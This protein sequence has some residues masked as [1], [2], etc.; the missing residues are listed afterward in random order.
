MTGGKALYQSLFGPIVLQLVLILLNAFFSCAEIAILTLNDLSLKKDADSGNKKARCL[1]RLTS[2]PSRFLATIQVGIT[3]AGFLASAFAAQNFSDRLVA[4]LINIGVTIPAETLGTLSVIAITLL[5]SYFTLVLGELVPKRIAMQKAKPI[6]YSVSRI[7]LLLSRITAPLVW[8]L[9]ASTNGILRL[10]RLSTHPKEANV[11]EEEIRMLVDLG[12]ERGAI[13]PDEGRMIDNVL[14]LGNKCAAE[15]M[16][17]RTDLV[18]LWMEESPEAWRDTIISA[19][20]SRYLVCSDS[21]D[22][23]AG[24]LHVR[25]F[26]SNMFLKEPQKRESI[27][28]PAFI[29]PETVRADVLFREMKHR[30]THMAVVI[31]EYGGLGGVITME[32]LLEEIVGQIEDE[33][34]FGEPMI[35]KLNEN[36][37]RAKGS[38][39]IGELS[40]YFGVALPEGDYDTLGGLIF[41]RLNSI[42]EDG[43]GIEADIAGLH[44]KVESLKYRRVEWAL[45]SKLPEKPKAKTI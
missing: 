14:E 37:W 26:F 5:L 19:N 24:I 20:Y 36:L 34:D 6:A 27:I 32:D 23:I 39:E 16:T 25:D 15:L 17:P 11:T 3:I 41:S 12:E 7:I 30:K 9:T 22:E 21:I 8:L 35:T 28:R 45:I 1:V 2:Q 40:D 33:H 4:W 29:V 42:P 18:V 38:A 44:I 43:T 10:L 31:D 13:E